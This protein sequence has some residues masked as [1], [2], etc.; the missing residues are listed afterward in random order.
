[1]SKL[2][3]QAFVKVGAEGVYCAALPKP[4]LGIAIKIDDGARR[5]AEV[6]TATLLSRL[7]S[8]ARSKLAADRV[9][10]QHNWRGLSTGTLAPSQ[11]LQ[12]LIAG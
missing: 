12:N 7:L 4:A 8:H 9:V 6:V 2:P 11:T 5:A 10:P 3:G 1:M